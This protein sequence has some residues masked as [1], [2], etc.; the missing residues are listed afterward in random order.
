MSRIEMVVDKC[1]G[2]RSCIKYEPPKQCYD[3][4][5]ICDRTK[6]LIAV[7]TSDA[8]MCEIPIPS[9]CPLE[10]YTETNECE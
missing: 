3:P 4:A 6:Q 2:C 5:F 1:I 10:I 7:T 8:E 9:W